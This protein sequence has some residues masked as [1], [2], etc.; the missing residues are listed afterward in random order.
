[1]CVYVC[2]CVHGILNT[3]LNDV[4]LGTN[5]TKAVAKSFNKNHIEHNPIQ[6]LSIHIS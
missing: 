1:V 5:T 2:V 3:Y 4:I 6:S